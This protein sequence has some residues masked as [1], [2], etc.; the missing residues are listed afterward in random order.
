MLLFRWGADPIV[1][2][3]DREFEPIVQF[4]R[5]K[6]LEG[7]MATIPTPVGKEAARLVAAVASIGAGETPAAAKPT[8]T[9]ARALYANTA[10][11]DKS[12]EPK[13]VSPAQFR[14]QTADSAEY[15]DD[16]VSPPLSRNNVVVLSEEPKIEAYQDF[17][18]YSDVNSIGQLIRT[19]GSGWL[20]ENMQCAWQLLRTHTIIL[21]R[22]NLSWCSRSGTHQI[23]SRRY[24]RPTT[25]AANFGAAYHRMDKP[26]LG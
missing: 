23:F 18:S 24:C 14:A 26:C 25:C 10:A 11:G 17:I 1:Y 8:Y 7:P 6:L 2:A 4:M 12:T 22:P 5:E 19:T 15:K 9:D 20:N 21:I 13:N 16:P 3:G